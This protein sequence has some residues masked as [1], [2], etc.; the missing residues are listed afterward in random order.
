MGKSRVSI[1]RC[2][3]YSQKEV[4][5]A[6]KEALSIID[7]RFSKGVTVLLKPNIL[8]PKKPEFAVTTHPA[9]VE[10]VC[11][12]L[13]EK[14]CRIIIG[15]SDGAGTTKKGFEVSGIGAIAKKHGA[16]TIV[17]ETDAKVKVKNRKN[18]VLKEFFVAKTLKDADLVINLPK[19]KTHSLT[20]YT[21]AVKNVFGVIPGATKTLYHKKAPDVN[22]FSHLL[23]DIYQ[24]VKPQLN[25]MDAIVGMEGLGP[26]AGTPKK[27]GY[28]IASR[29]CVAL[30][31]VASKLAGFVPETIRTIDYAFKRGISKKDEI[32]IFGKEGKINDD[33]LKGMIV[34]YKK[35]PETNDTLMAFGQ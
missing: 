19:L 30:D 14:K 17:F 11:K 12:L 22:R 28:I 33:K 34:P 32:E 18:L 2:S 15:E 3:S 6:V 20:K 5:A 26:G 24:S 1:V 8:S 16:K 35:A 21:G 10:A 4:Y 7:F 25:I 13:K 27:T 23:L 31:F 9:I 29:D